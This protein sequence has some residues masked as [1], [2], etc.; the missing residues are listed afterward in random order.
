MDR[1]TDSARQAGAFEITPAM[2]EAGATALV[3]SGFLDS[4]YLGPA[5]VTGPIRLLTLEVLVKSLPQKIVG[6]SGQSVREL[7]KT[8]SRTA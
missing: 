8:L 4:D 2:I 3:N 5:A 7:R 6:P 1:P